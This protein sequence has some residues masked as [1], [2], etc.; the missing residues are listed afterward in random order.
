MGRSFSRSQKEACWDV[1]APVPGRD[2]ERWR[3]DRYNNPVCRRLR[4]CDGCLCH[5]FDHIQPHSK[6]G[7]SSLANCQLLQT[8][9]NRRKGNQ[10]IDDA[11]MGELGCEIKFSERELDLVEMAVYGNVRRSGL[12]CRCKSVD[13]MHKSM[14]DMKSRKAN[15][16]SAS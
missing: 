5:E 6:G 12:N 3:L 15:G 9:V 10:E 16:E 2:P 13:E 7:P 8:R 14:E 11:R 1:A 4:G